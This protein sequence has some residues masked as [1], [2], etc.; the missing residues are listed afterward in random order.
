MKKPSIFPSLPKNLSVTELRKEI[1]R[2]LKISEQ[3]G[4][5]RKPKKWVAELRH[6]LAT[7]AKNRHFKVRHVADFMVGC[8]CLVTII[9]ITGMVMPLKLIESSLLKVMRWSNILNL[10]LLSLG[11]LLQSGRSGIWCF[12][13]FAFIFA[14]AFA[15]PR[16]P[17]EQAIAFRTLTQDD[18]SFYE[19]NTWIADYSSVLCWSNTLLNPK[20]RIIIQGQSLGTELIFFEMLTSA[21]IALLHLHGPL[22]KPSRWWHSKQ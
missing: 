20:Q 21:S 5:I 2:R 16:M 4:L 13:V 7:L 9:Q 12:D 18:L 10:C 8:L 3:L 22:P 11:R 14:N 17:T 6:G 15:T 19:C 1:R